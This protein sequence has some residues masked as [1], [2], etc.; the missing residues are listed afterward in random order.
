M[1]EVENAA[2]NIYIL[3]R[4]T[5]TPTNCPTAA[6]IYL[7]I[8]INMRCCVNTLITVELKEINLFYLFNRAQSPSPRRNAIYSSV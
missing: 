2:S 7:F 3:E 4:I 1:L 6:S 5:R 8:D